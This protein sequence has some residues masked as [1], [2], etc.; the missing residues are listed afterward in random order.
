[1]GAFLSVG[2]ASSEESLFMEITY[3]GADDNGEK[4]LVFVGKGSNSYSLCFMIWFKVQTDH[5]FEGGGVVLLLKWACID[6]NIMPGSYS[7]FD[8][9]TPRSIY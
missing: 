8:I 5:I 1:M 9:T 2:K 7:N 4:P 6:I 3:H